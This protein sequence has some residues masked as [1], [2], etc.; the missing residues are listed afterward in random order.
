MKPP[1]CLLQIRMLLTKKFNYHPWT[2][3][4]FNKIFKHHNIVLTSQNKYSI[5]NLLNS[6]LKDH[7]PS[8]KKSSIIMSVARI[9]RKQKEI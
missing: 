5:N 7:I 2:Y 8:G 9:M 1:Q 3:D 6:N 4:K